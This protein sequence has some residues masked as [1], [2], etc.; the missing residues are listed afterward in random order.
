MFSVD[1]STRECDG[2][3]V[4]A[5]RGELDL[6]DA[7]DVAATLAA[8]VARE[9]RVVVDLAGLEFIDCGGVA[10]LARG[11]RHAQQAGGDLLLAAPQQR[12][13]RVVAITRLAGEFSVHASVEEAGRQRR[14]L[15]AGGRA[16][17]AAA[18]QDTL[19]AARRAVR[20]ASPGERSTVTRDSRPEGAGARSPSAAAQMGQCPSWVA[21]Y[22]AGWP[23][24]GRAR[25]S[26]QIRC[27]G[28]A[29]DR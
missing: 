4:V 5:L 9:P 7:A 21:R 22:P 27:A 13:L 15:P 1:L 3:V 8:A 6:V 14:T 2:H 16:G 26:R 18:Q 20:N 12:V 24:G 29:D 17:A 11:R 19:A 10:A 28:G 25:S 23:R